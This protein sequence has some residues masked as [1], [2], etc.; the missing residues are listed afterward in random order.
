MFIAQTF[1]AMCNFIA[2]LIALHCGM[3][4]FEIVMLFSSGSAILNAIYGRIT[5]NSILYVPSTSYKYLLMRCVFGVLGLNFYTQSF[6][7]MNISIAYV[8]LSTLP[9]GTSI[10]ASIILKERLSK[11]D[12]IGSI[13]AFI[14]VI[15][16]MSPSKNT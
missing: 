9:I 8:I 12:I 7:V 16:I 4:S 14:G 3:Q 10:A 11:Y 2:K 1:F 15:L 5:N 6:I 13:F